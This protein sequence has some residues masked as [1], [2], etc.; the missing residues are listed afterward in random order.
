MK[1][2]P[3]SDMALAELLIGVIELLEQLTNNPIQKI[4][5]NDASEFTSKDFKDY[6]MATGINVVHPM[7]LN[8]RQNDLAKLSMM[9]LNIIAKSLMLKAKLPT[10]I[11]GHAILHVATLVRILPTTYLG[12]SPIQ[13][14]SRFEPNVSHL[15]IF[16]CAVYVYMAHPRPMKMEPQRSLGIYVGFKSPSIVKY[17]KPMTREVSAARFHDCTID[18]TFFP[19]LGGE[20]A[21]KI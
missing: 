13:L 8:D 3:T 14:V 7:L 9:Q 16:G 2:L 1:L 17:L 21:V 10:T 6:C 12:C 5:L 11:W 20:L 18:E 19:T 15:C 4:L